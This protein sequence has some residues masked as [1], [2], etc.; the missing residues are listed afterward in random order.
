MLYEQSEITYLIRCQQCKQKYDQYHPHRILP[1][2]YKTIC[3]ECVLAVKIDMKNKTFKC[4]IYQGYGH[5]PGKGFPI[6]EVLLQLIEKQPNEMKFT[7]ESR[8]KN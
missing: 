6:N 2:C 5:I 8:L 3:Y 4:V 7:E 1:C